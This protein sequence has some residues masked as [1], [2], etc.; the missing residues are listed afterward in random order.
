M[1]KNK[2]VLT[3]AEK[4][5]KHGKSIVGVGI[6]YLVCSVI[7]IFLQIQTLL[8]PISLIISGVQI[9]TLLAMVIGVKKREKYGI[10]AA[11]IFEAWMIVGLIL[12]FVG[13]AR[14]D[15]IGLIVM[16]W[17][18]SDIKNYSKALKELNNTTSENIDSPI[19]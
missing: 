19:T 3:P 12:T 2:K 8:N 15:L 10:T 9:A 1:S 17:L 6:F 18:P 4:V 7:V 5:E 11:W 14:T 13:M 16:I